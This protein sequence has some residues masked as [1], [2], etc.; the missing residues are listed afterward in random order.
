LFG[1]SVIVP[2]INLSLPTEKIVAIERI[3]KQN[4]VTKSSVADKYLKLPSGSD[5]VEQRFVRVR[6]I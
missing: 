3:A 4:N 6:D 1:V 2:S 5:Q